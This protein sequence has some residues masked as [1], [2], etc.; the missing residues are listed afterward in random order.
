MSSSRGL[1]KQSKASNLSARFAG[2]CKKD[3]WFVPGL[4]MW[5]F[6]AFLLVSSSYFGVTCTIFEF[7]YKTQ[8]NPYLDEVFHIPQARRYCDGNFTEWDPKITTLPGLYFLTVGF[9]KPIS[10]FLSKPELCS[11]VYALRSVN[12]ILSTGLLYVVYSLL[13]QIHGHKEELDVVRGLLTAVNMCL[14]PVLYF[15]NFLYYTDVMST[16]LILFAYLL[17]LHERH[18]LSAFTGFLAVCVRQTNIVWVLFLSLLTFADILKENAYIN[19]KKFTVPVVRSYKYLEILWMNSCQVALVNSSAGKV[20]L[21]NMAKKLTGYFLVVVTFTVFVLWNGSIVVGDKQAHQASLHLT[22]VLYFSVF[23]LFFMLP[24]ALPYAFSLHHSL[25]RRV[26]PAA[27]GMLF[28]IAIVHFNTIAHPYLLAD[29]RHY[30]FYVWRRIINREWWSR[31]MITPFYMLGCILIASILKRTDFVFQVGFIFCLIASIV[32]QSLLEFRYFIIPYM[33]LRL[34]I[35]KPEIWQLL[36]EMGLY[37]LVNASTILIFS[38]K[39]IKW[40]DMEEPQRFL[41]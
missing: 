20:L 17:S 10:W 13:R 6:A 18:A 25:R 37:V 40:P 36:S 22:Q 23:V 35:L 38:Q 34:Q 19:K 9:L 1:S 12:M 31:Y 21:M 24:F 28:I 32:P 2:T 15:F 16:F 26:V 41:W 8:P 33:L 4:A 27:I 3:C 14:F 29:N 39:T 7:L 30:T 5:L 11:S